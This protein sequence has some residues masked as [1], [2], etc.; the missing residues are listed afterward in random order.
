MDER[1]DRRKRAAQHIGHLFIAQL[2]LPAKQERNSLIIGQI[3]QG[4]IDFLF[5]F[6]LQQLIRRAN[7]FY[8]LV[9]MPGLVFLLR[10]GGVHRVRRMPRAPPDFIE[11]K[12]SGDG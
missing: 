3:R 7:R 11:R 2:I 9:L 4:I 1:F 8:I 10:G 12:V 5:E 6:P